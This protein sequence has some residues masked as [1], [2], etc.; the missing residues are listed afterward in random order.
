[1]PFII[2]DSVFL[3][4]T[5]H[6]YKSVGCYQTVVDINSRERILW[7]LDSK[8]LTSHFAVSLLAAMVHNFVFLLYYCV[9][10]CLI[11]Y[12]VNYY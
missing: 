11:I 7:L 9:Y 8:T 3:L 6:G 2:L 1:M 10:M 4:F 12:K 5:I